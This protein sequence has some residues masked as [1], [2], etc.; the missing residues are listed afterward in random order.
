MVVLICSALFARP[1]LTALRVLRS[2][3][4]VERVEEELRYQ[5]TESHNHP[6][7]VRLAGMLLHDCWFH[8]AAGL[9]LTSVLTT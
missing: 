1:M 7:V 2:C 9:S 4:P 5:R 6:G 3:R 8:G